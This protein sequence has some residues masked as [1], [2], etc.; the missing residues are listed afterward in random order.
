MPWE[1][2]GL[3]P[4]SVAHVEGHTYRV[5]GVRFRIGPANCPPYIGI[6]G[7]VAPRLPID[8][9]TQEIDG[10]AATVWWVSHLRVE[11]DAAPLRTD[12]KYPDTTQARR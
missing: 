6:A 11:I 8:T 9:T 2:D 12:M 3:V 10:G 5:V 4:G 7:G 1:A